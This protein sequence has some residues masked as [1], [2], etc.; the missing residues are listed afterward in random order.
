M[1]K[2]ELLKTTTL[3]ET[4]IFKVSGLHLRFSNSKE[5]HFE[6][7]NVHFSGAVMI[8]PLLDD[9]TLLLTREY[10][11]AANEYTLGFPKGAIDNLGD[12]VLETANRELME[13][14]GYGA[15]DLRWL[16]KMS[17]SPAYFNA[18]MDIVLAKDLYPKKLEGDE[19]EPIEVIP[20]KIKDIDALL[21]HPEF[22]ESRSIAAVL[23][24]ERMQRANQL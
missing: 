18:M 12:D 17:L 10:A 13:E 22:T 21:A 16:M 1:P 4:K 7:I 6:K 14:A 15:N 11:A 8:V 19:P 3:A 9:E 23:L 20:W 5:F 24:I 2:P